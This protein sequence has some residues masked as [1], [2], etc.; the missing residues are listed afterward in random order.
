VLQG[1]TGLQ[2]SQEQG[3]WF[4]QSGCFSIDSLPQVVLYF[5]TLP[6]PLTPRQYIVQV[7]ICPLVCR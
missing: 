3:T 5:G 7:R 2:F 1:I 6:V 4:V